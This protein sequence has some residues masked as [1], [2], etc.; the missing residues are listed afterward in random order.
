MVKTKTSIFCQ[1][2]KV[3][4]QHLMNLLHLLESWNQSED[5]FDELMLEAGQDIIERIDCTLKDCMSLSTSEWSALYNAQKALI[6]AKSMANPEAKP[7]ALNEDF[8][9]AGDDTDMPEDFAITG[10]KDG[11]QNG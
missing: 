9:P 10:C 1:R 11:E 6:K 3:D 5:D 4:V 2:M 8:A 7:E